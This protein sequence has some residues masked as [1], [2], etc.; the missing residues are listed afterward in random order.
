[1][2]RRLKLG[3]GRW[4]VTTLALVM[5]GAGVGM[6]SLTADRPLSDQPAVNTQTC[7]IVDTDVGVDDYRALATFLPKR[8]LR[9]VVVTEGISGVQGGST[10]VSMFLASRSDTPPV[11]PGLAS[12][13]PPAYDWLP[14]ARAGAE[15]MNNY[16]HSAVPFG[17]SPDRL[18]S[19]VSSAVRGCGRVDVLVLGPWT[20]YLRYVS[21]LGADV[22]VVA[23]G[24]SFAENNPDN[25]NCEYDLQACRT[26]ATVLRSARSVVFVDLPPAGADPTDPTYD[27]TEAMVARFEQAGMPGLLRTALQVDPSQW[28]GTRLWD[29]AAALYL[30]APGAFERNGGHVEPAVS[31]D[32]F[33]NLLINAINAD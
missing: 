19:D 24:R 21:A 6:Q 8:D 31:E 2:V 1:M 27:P 9:A 11:I 15:R 30:I 29:D 3:L 10:A 22:R 26:A 14:A 32:T 5:G 12:A 20:S 13:T 4:S 23:S 7:L 16:L 17:V 25:F 28:L 33:R 18:K